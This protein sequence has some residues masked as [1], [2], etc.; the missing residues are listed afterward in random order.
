MKISL[1][2][3]LNIIALIIIFSILDVVFLIG[4]YPYFLFLFI[5]LIMAS[6][7]QEIFKNKNIIIISKAL[8]ILAIIFLFYTAIQNWQIRYQDEQY[9]KKIN[10]YSSEL[11]LSQIDSFLSNKKISYNNTAELLYQQETI[12]A[13]LFEN[14]KNANNH[15]HISVYMLRDHSLGTELKELLI[16]KAKQEIKVRVIY[17]AYGSLY[18]S[19]NYIEELKNAGVRIKEFNSIINSF[20]EGRMNHRNHRKIFIIDGKIGYIGD[21]NI[22]DDYFNEK[23]S[24]MLKIKG[25]G[26][27]SLQEIFLADWYYLTEEKI[28]LDEYYPNHKYQEENLPITVISSAYDR[29]NN[30]IYDKYLD[31]IREAKNS[32][33]IITPYLSFDNHIYNALKLSRKK[34]IEINIIVSEKTEHKI[35]SWKNASFYKKL[36]NAE[37]NIFNYQ[38]NILH[39]KIVL[40]DKKLLSIGSAN[41][42]TRSFFLDYESNAIIH[43]EKISLD[44]MDIINI[45]LENSKKLLWKN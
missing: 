32:I 10:K 18:L 25:E 44:L 29:Q 12:I 4:L 28:H 13:D 20:F 16:E 37:I 8:I 34:G 26:V 7:I 43:D 27:H 42:N 35:L 45:Y 6:I 38:K 39:S 14:I 15:I 21:L 33:Y 36:L 40:I 19:R 30:H 41:F 2:F 11:A 24:L 5:I 3:I 31:L 9:L 1:F 23:N 17:D 22:G